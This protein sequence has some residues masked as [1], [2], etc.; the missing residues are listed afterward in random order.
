MSSLARASAVMASGTMVSRALGFVKAI[1]LVQAIG[2]TASVSADAFANGNFL[3]NMIYAVMMGGMLNAVLV[4]QIVK[5]SQGADR[6][7][8]YINKLTTL[9]I[10]SLSVVTLVSMVF[11]PLLTWAN[12]VTWSEDQL[13]LATAFAYWC[14]PQI[15]F[16]GLFT[17]LGEVLNARKVFGPFTWAPALNN[18]VGCAGII[19]FIV[20]YGNDP[21][22]TR[23]VEWWGFDSVALLAG[24]AT[25]G[26]VAQAL[27]LFVS[28]KKAGIHFKFDFGWR[29]IGLRKTVQVGGWVLFM[30][31]TQQLVAVLVNSV[32]NG[33]SG[34]GLAQLAVQNARLISL[35]PHSVVAV[36][37]AT[38]FFTRLSETGQ[39]GDIPGFKAAL[40]QMFRVIMMLMLI[41]AV[42]LFA[43]SIPVSAVMQSG[44]TEEQIRMF[45]VLI[46]AYAVGV[47]PLSL[48]FVTFRAFYALSDTK[49][50][51]ILFLI[52]SAVEVPLIFVVFFGVPATQAAV[53]LALL[54]AVV[55]VCQF[56]AGMM[57]LRRR[58]GSIGFR[59]W[60]L[61]LLHQL[62]AV[63]VAGAGGWYVW[64]LFEQIALSSGFIG[65]ALGCVGVAA[66]V[67]ALYFAVCIVIRVPEVGRVVGTLKSRFVRK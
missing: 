29:G 3:P 66:V 59:G 40:N 48:Q 50:V 25:L 5:A 27:I 28:W 19:V 39:T 64:K 18:V 38:A 47:L 58:F 6:G 36:S 21:A 55:N 20:I 53:I 26:I 57:I 67:I 45:A 10:V 14:L 16:Y 7:Q 62:P 24:S 8:A 60:M 54:A 52:T 61:S 9:V 34:E 56:V 65:A 11:A 2:Q 23:G 30:V 12:G 41:S 49:M 15:L 13:S 46:Q 44:A 22:G 42:I 31:I 33:A 1:L 32:V 43:V 17:V 63:L 37:V 4:P 35:L 51:F